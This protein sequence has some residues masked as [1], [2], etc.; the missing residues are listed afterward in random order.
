LLRLLRLLDPGNHGR[1]NRR[2]VGN[3]RCFGCLGFLL[4]SIRVGVLF[5][6]RHNW[7]RSILVDIFCGNIDRDKEI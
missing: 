1:L 4:I 5:L 6:A 3:I 2:E 7:F